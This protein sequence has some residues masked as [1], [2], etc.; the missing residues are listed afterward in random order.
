MDKKQLRQ[1]IRQRKSEC[2]IPER[3]ERSKAVIA[4]LEADEDYLKARNVLCYWSLPDEVDTHDFVI[5]A[6]ASKRLF[7]P[8]VSGDDLLIREFTG[9]SSLCEGENYSIPEPA[10]GSVQAS[11]SD[12]DLVVVPGVAFDRKGGRM[13]RGKGFYDRLLQ[14]SD[15]V[16]IGI[17]FGFQ[18]VDE[19]PM[20]E[21][22]I[23]MDKVISE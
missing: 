7:L 11:I 4:A 15:V 23:L 9:V 10:I 2:P 5:R 18:L 16:K 17:C 12:I 1:L 8:V 3:I 6:A 21:H 22:D 19:V 14:G 20:Q 13:G